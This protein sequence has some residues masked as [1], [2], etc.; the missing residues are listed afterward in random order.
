MAELA[1]SIIG[2]AITRALRESPE[3]VAA[4]LLRLMRREAELEAEN[5]ELRWRLS[6]L[7]PITGQSGKKWDDPAGGGKK[8]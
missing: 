4:D 3:K 7:I 6:L 8:E 1:D 5:Q 2:F